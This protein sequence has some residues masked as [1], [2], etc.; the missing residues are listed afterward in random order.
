MA[1]LV[2]ELEE[3]SAFIADVVGIDT[4]SVPPP[5]SESASAPASASVG[6]GASGSEVS[7]LP[8]LPKTSACDDAADDSAVDADHVEREDE[9][10]AKSL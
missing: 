5:V 1:E 4:V 6:V 2:L 7:L 9:V 3:S 10:S 8:P